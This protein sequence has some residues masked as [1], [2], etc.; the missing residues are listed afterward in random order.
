MDVVFR[1]EKLGLNDRLYNAI[2]F[3]FRKPIMPYSY[4]LFRFITLTKFY[5]EYELLLEYFLERVYEYF[6]KKL[7]GRISPIFT[8]ILMGNSYYIT[9]LQQT[10]FIFATRPKF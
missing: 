9:R 4:C 2:F 6:L 1:K 5:Y 7:F 3:Q 10:I 8:R